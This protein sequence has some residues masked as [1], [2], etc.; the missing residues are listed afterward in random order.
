[1]KYYNKWEYSSPYYLEQS[2]LWDEYVVLDEDTKNIQVNTNKFASIFYTIVTNTNTYFS[3]WL[4]K[5]LNKVIFDTKTWE[6]LFTEDEKMCLNSYL[7]YSY[8]WNIYIRS[9]QEIQH[10]KWIH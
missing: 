2:L 4:D 10:F 1:M 3:V 8:E 5:K 6:I 7:L 9:D